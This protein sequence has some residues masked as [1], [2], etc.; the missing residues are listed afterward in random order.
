MHAAGANLAGGTDLT[1]YSAPTVGD[2]CRQRWCYRHRLHVALYLQT[3]GAG[4]AIVPPDDRCR[5]DVAGFATSH[6]LLL[7]DVVTFKV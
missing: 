1:P 4:A 7:K 6:G 5:F 2:E 3:A